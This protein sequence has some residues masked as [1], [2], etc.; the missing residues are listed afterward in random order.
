[1]L[2]GLGLPWDMMHHMADDATRQATQAA[3]HARAGLLLASQNKIA[4]AVAHLSQWAALQ[5][6]SFEARYNFGKALRDLRQNEQAAAEFRAAVR[7]N[8]AFAQA[9]NNLGNSLRDLL[10][11]DEALE[12]YRKSLELRPN[13]APTI[14]NMALLYQDQ[15]CTDDAM[16]AFDRAIALKPDYAEAI[17]GKAMLQLLLGDYDNGW[18]GYEA[19]WQV[20]GGVA[21]RDFRQPLW[22]GSDLSGKRI[23][24]H[25]EQGFGD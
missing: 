14:H 13:H 11:F 8:P 2:T 3:Q 12:C 20:P 9:W 1:M 22:D 18:C 5:P 21:P 7:L 15:L 10:A 4:E 19:R 23:L 25:A 16:R 24:L 17:A 6:Q